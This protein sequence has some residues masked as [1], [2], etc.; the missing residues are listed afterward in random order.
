MGSKVAEFEEAARR[1]RSGPR[2]RPRSRPAPPRCTSRSSRSGSAR[3]T[4]SSSPPTHFPRP[5]TSSSCV[6]RR[7]SSS[8]STRTRSTSTRARRRRRHAAHARGARR[9]P[10]RPPGRVG[11]APDRGP[12]GGRPRRGRSGRARSP[13]PRDAVRRARVARLPLVPPAQDRDDRRGRR[14]HDRR[15]RARRRRAAASAPRLVGAGRACRRQD[16]T[17]GLPDV[18][19][20][21][22]I[23]QLA[24]LEEL[25]EARERVARLVRGAARAPR[26]HSRAPQRE[27][28][29]A[30]R[31]TSSS[32]T[33]ATRRSTRCARQGIEAQIGTWAL[34]RLGP[35]RE[36]GSFPGADRA[37][38][39]ALALPFATTTTEDEVD[40][41]PSSAVREPDLTAVCE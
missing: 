40:R 20:A 4:R 15:G 8:T 37:F 19:C 12:A 41:V 25:L 22:G 11:G 26:R 24:R 32:S 1:A 21:I 18:L 5:R 9:P 33:A 34:H 27:T 39:R 38:E 10:V 17:T 14:D 7:R 13:L 3:A 6:A 31:R 23:P 36:Q 16:S 29:T 35:Y 30:G 2:T 28:A